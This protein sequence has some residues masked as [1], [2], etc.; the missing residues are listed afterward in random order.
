MIT[1]G[2]RIPI[3]CL[4]LLLVEVG[5]LEGLLDLHLLGAGVHPGVGLAVLVVPVLNDQGHD[6]QPDADKD[7]DEHAT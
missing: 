2:F 4:V 7:D 1:R 5:V 6:S 3:L